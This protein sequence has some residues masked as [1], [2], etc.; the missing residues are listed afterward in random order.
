MKFN[1][2]ILIIIIIIVIRCKYQIIYLVMV[3]YTTNQEEGIGKKLSFSVSQVLFDDDVFD[4]LIKHTAYIISSI[5]FT[6]INAI[7]ISL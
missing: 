3:V 6:S 4:P 5:S 2:I 1:V 7:Y